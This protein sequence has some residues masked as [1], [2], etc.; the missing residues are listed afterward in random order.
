LDKEKFKNYTQHIEQSEENYSFTNMEPCSTHVNMGEVEADGDACFPTP[1]KNEVYSC[2]K[3]HW[4]VLFEED[5]LMCE[6]KQIELS[7]ATKEGSD[8]RPFNAYFDTPQRRFPCAD[9]LNAPARKKIDRERALSRKRLCTMYPPD[10]WIPEFPEYA[11]KHERFKSFE[12]WPKQIYQDATEL[13][14]AGFFYRNV[15]DSVAC[16]FC[17]GGL[18]NWDTADIPMREHKEKYPNCLF[19]IMNTC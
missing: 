1:P 6:K 16:F 7:T 17:G 12:K 19:V 9:I 14:N 4:K 3:K 10:K 18:K 5:S 11:D 8:F 15:G 2:P 13:S